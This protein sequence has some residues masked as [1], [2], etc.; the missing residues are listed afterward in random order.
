MQSDNI[1][2]D[3]DV[4]F[5]PGTGMDIDAVGPGM[6][7]NPQFTPSPE[8]C[9]LELIQRAAYSPTIY[10]CWGTKDSLALKEYIFVTFKKHSI[11]PELH[12]VH[13]D[14][15][16]VHGTPD[17]GYT[18]RFASAA[19]AAQALSLLTVPDWTYIQESYAAEVIVMASNSWELT[20]SEL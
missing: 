3:S 17:F 6:C 14:P 18:L 15:L 13:R 9:V 11:L 4:T 2:A 5:S 20:A 1:A 16:P 12:S 10:L 19:A 7:S 8:F